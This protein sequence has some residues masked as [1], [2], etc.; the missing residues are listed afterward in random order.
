M[1]GETRARWRLF[2]EQVETEDDPVPLV[3]IYREILCIL[4]EKAASLF[5]AWTNELES[6]PN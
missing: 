3:G 1:T 5:R 4:D 2:C 6:K